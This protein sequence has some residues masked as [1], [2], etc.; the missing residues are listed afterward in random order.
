MSN[1]KYLTAL[2]RDDISQWLVH[3]T[4]SGRINGKWYAADVVLRSIINSQRVE[5]SLVEAITKYYAHGAA[6]FYDVPLQNWN[7]LLQT[8]P[9]GRQ[10]YGIIV[11]KAAFWAKGGRPAIYTENPSRQDWPAQERFRLITTVLD[12]PSPI[13][14]TH[15]REWRCPS[16]LELDLASAWWWPCV[17]N[18]RDALLLFR[19]FSAGVQ[20]VNVILNSIYVNE[21]RRVIGRNEVEPFLSDAACCT[22]L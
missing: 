14:W 19:D 9:N 10:P 11:S 5:P 8:N 16:G 13:D 12:Q 20:G 15:E 22:N 4:K 3:F 6:C 18:I 2:N 21:L 17:A 7:Q 1:Q